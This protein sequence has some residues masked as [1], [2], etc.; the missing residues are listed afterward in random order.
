MAVKLNWTRLQ[1]VTESVCRHPTAAGIRRRRHKAL[2]RP[3]L[4]PAVSPGSIPASA[5]LYQGALNRYRIKRISNLEYDQSCRY[6]S[7]AGLT[8]SDRVYKTSQFHRPTPPLRLPASYR[9]QRLT[10]F[11]RLIR[12]LPDGTCTVGRRTSRPPTPSVPQ[13]ATGQAT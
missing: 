7:F 1:S 8:D 12:P 3:G 9:R 13:K 4:S 5:T 11:A 10:A 2:M 6:T